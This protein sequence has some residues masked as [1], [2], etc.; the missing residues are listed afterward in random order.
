MTPV[1]DPRNVARL[2][3]TRWFAWCKPFNRRS[4]TTRRSRW[5]KVTCFCACGSSRLRTLVAHCHVGM[6]RWLVLKRQ[7][8]SK[9]TTC[10]NGTPW[11]THSQETHRKRI[12]NHGTNR[13]KPSRNGGFSSIFHLFCWF[14]G[15][16]RGSPRSPVPRLV[17]VVVQRVQEGGYW[18]W[19]CL[20]TWERN[21]YYGVKLGSLG[22]EQ[23][24]P[25]MMYIYI[26]ILCIIML[27][28]ILD[29]YF[30]GLH[31]WIF[32]DTPR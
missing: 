25:W 23:H 13:G 24:D 15:T 28:I 8:G 18:A 22:C 19:R 11:K 29:V 12:E 4:G 3:A 21:D 5:W 26:C 32:L 17:T 31:F 7:P 27:W 16:D 10:F 14:F 1:W 30:W 20:V 9:K 6:I 2:Q